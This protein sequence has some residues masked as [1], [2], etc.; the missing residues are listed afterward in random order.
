[1]S[2]LLDSGPGSLRQAILD[3]PAGGTVSFQPGL[4]GTITLSTGELAIDK[5]LNIAGPGAN[6][7]AVS[8]NNHS[9]VFDISAAIGVDISGLTIANGNADF[10]VGGNGGGVRNDGALT[11]RNCTISG[12]SAGN[13]DGGGIENFGFLIVCGST[14][15]GNSVQGG[16][17]GGIFDRGSGLVVSNST[18]NGNSTL[19]TGGGIFCESG[20]VVLNCCTLS[21]NSADEGGGIW[22]KAAAT[23]GLANTIIAG[24]A[25]LVGPDLS[26]SVVSLG[27]NLFGNTQGGS[28][29]DVSDLLNIDPR[30]GP[31]R[32]NGGPT[33]T[34][35]LRVGSPAIDAGNDAF[36]PGPY[37]Q[38]GPGFARLVNHLDIGAFE[39]QRPPVVNPTVIFPVLWPPNPVLINVGLSVAVTA[40]QAALS[41]QVY[42][43]DAADAY[44]A[45]G[46]GPETL[47]LR[48]ERQDSG[49][50]RVYLI[51]SQATDPSG[52]TGVGVC[53]VVVPRDDSALALAQVQAAAGVAAAYYLASQTAPPGFQLLGPGPASGGNPA[54]LTPSVVL[55][56]VPVTQLT[57]TPPPAVGAPAAPGV[58][59]G[60]G[61]GGPFNGATTA[62]LT[63]SPITSGADGGGHSDAGI[64]G[65][66]LSMS[67]VDDPFTKEPW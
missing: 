41:V 11:I 34:M 45:A 43:N 60:G 18:L 16:S 6:L 63:S 52:Q 24:N 49:Q 56:T 39:V 1:V 25:A 58:N 2:N 14:L 4:N 59:V 64:I 23:L 9:R 8:G 40:P 22:N 55:V 61:L 65:N 29:F 53:T 27:H 46:I 13:G 26:G 66:N 50:G 48:A 30:L 20:L 44:D 15:S 32:D 37:D 12:N 57:P 7:I 62:V 28:G 17:G 19:T 67:N 31:L 21:G 35:A 51:V 33:Q 5:N 36:A 47:Q 42:A 10:S 38:R 3:T 54:A